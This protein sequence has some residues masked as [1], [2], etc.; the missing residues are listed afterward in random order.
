MP[1]PE[2]RVDG[3]D[4]APGNN[5]VTPESEQPT[6]FSGSDAPTTEAVAHEAPVTPSGDEG[7]EPASDTA[8]EVAAAAAAETLPEAA[9]ETDASSGVESPDA[10]ATGVLEI[11]SSLDEGDQTP[12][13]SETPAAEPLIEVPAAAAETA[14]DEVT[15]AADQSAVVDTPSAEDAREAIVEIEPPEAA[16]QTAAGDDVTPAAE[17][18]PVEQAAAEL[19]PEATLAPA[20][21]ADA[22]ETEVTRGRVPWWPFAAYLGLWVAGLGYATYRFMQV[23]AGRP[24]YEQVLYGYFVIGGLV[25]TALGPVLIPFVWLLGRAGLEKPQ[26]GGLFARTAFWAALATLLG[27]GMWWLTIIALDSVRLGSAL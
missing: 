13:R 20:P 24:L 7:A 6:L 17:G 19:A 18:A 9:P 22:A 1:E 10:F 11:V 21:V 4:A 8:G 5:P 12:A 27:V 16:G 23:P 26:R 25:L 2:P 14:A 15:A 3:T